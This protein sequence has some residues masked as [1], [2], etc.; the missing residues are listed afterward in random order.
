MIIAQRQ[1][2]E[3]PIHVMELV[4]ASREKEPVRIGVPFPR[5][6]LHDGSQLW[7][8]DPEGQAFPVQ[9]KIL[10][11][12]PDRSIK[13]LLVDFFASVS[14]DFKGKFF[15]V[16]G[17]TAKILAISTVAVEEDPDSFTVSAG[18]NVWKVFKTK[19]GIREVWRGGCQVSGKG[20]EVILEGRDGKKKPLL[21]KKTTLQAMGSLRCDLLQEGWFEVNKDW[22]IN[23]RLRLSFF[24][25]S[26]CVKLEA[27]LHN[28]RAAIHPGGLWDLGDPGSFF[29][30][31]LSLCVTPSSGL[32]R[33]KWFCGPTQKRGESKSSLWVLHQNSSGGENWN[34]LNHID[35]D[36]RLTVSFKGYKVFEGSN[37]SLVHEGERAE[38]VVKIETQQ[39]SV[40]AC[41][42]NFWQAFPKT[43]KVQDGS[44]RVGLFPGES[45][46]RYELQGGEQKRHVAYL[47]FSAPGQ[48][49]GLANMLNPLHVYID[50]AWIEQTAAIP[51]FSEFQPSEEE[52]EGYRYVRRIID[53]EHS[54][55]EK[56]ELVDE[57]GWRNFGDTYADHE[58]VNHKGKEI[59]VSHYNNQY[60]FIYGALIHHLRT[61]DHR[62][63]Q[64][65]ADAANHMI[66]IDIYHT[67]GD[68]PGFNHGQFWHT[69]HYLPAQT[70]THRGYSKKNL[71]SLGIPASQYGGG[72]SNEQDYSSGLLY[73]YFLTGDPESRQAVL[74]LAQ[75]VMD[76]DDGK[77]S[78]LA[79]FDEGPTGLASQTREPSYHK[80]GRG[81]GNSINTL[82]DAYNVDLERKYLAKAEEFILR[83]IHPLDDINSLR[84][85]DPENRW[86][87]L[88]FLQI[89]GRYLNFKAEQGE[90]D[91]CYHYARES[92][93]HYAEW[94]ATHEAPFK[95]SFHKVD[96]P[97][98][99]WPAHDIRK[100]HV[101]HL[102]AHYSAGKERDLFKEK[103]AFFYRRCLDD[104]FGFE[105]SKFA[106]PL[107]I[108]ALYDYIN[109]FFLRNGYKSCEGTTHNYNFGAPVDFSPQRQ[110]F[111]KVFAGKF[112]S[113]FHAGKL[114]IKEKFL[115]IGSGK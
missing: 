34:S 62:W 103:A 74:E 10:S 108:I 32:E 86:S 37:G 69:D 2:I 27:I 45:N 81:G 44:L 100:T 15:L 7:C 112:F 104:L 110:R 29:F 91:Y 50:P 3:I 53:G 6:M 5:G 25:S 54:F 47:E 19:G 107:I 82:L 83:C 21:V 89:L 48:E 46:S 101:F 105:T 23:L 65:M 95:E 88:V 36:G 13:W 92:L 55:F 84:L 63:R 40:A 77:K 99:T 11:H 31:D 35:K 20:L 42:E 67:D 56:R 106:R 58:A 16:S 115:G 78:I 76:M 28:P 12:W 24:A 59:F 102:A 94:M 1:N 22:R 90:K 61:G 38:P 98:E 68:K 41:V 17:T 85:D 79:I 64:L 97:T 49:T 57:Y 52:A 26:G 43:I 30:R 14:A 73:Y 4:G 109:T 39:G 8:L 66:D 114:M 96:I 60:D 9:T 18:G 93:L 80:A 33:I 87:Y 70:S 113:T 72:P 111:A 75:W 71:P 51:Y